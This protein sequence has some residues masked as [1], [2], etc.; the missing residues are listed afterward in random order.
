M[1]PPITLTNFFPRLFHSL[2]CRLHHFFCYRLYHADTIIL[3]QHHK[4]VSIPSPVQV[5]LVDYTML[6]DILTFQEAKYVDIFKEFLDQGD[7]GYFG[8][9]DGVC[10]FR[11]WVKQGP[12]QVHLHPLWPLELTA[13]Q[14]YIHYCETAPQARGKQIYPHVLAHIAAEFSARFQIFISTSAK[15]T[16][17]IHGIEKAGYREIARKQL[18]G[19]LGFT[20]KKTK[21]LADV[22]A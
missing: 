1:K 5:K 2:Y 16:P 13:Q 15:N 18:V 3:F 12:Q 6:P 19:L 20:I 9:L 21:R 10:V 17:S 7:R 11:A 4:T 14:L 8:Y 22:R